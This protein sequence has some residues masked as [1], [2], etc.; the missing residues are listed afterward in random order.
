MHEGRRARD[1]FCVNWTRSGGGGRIDGGKRGGGKGEGIG[2]TK[3]AIPT[4]RPC[5]A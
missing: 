3:T 4:F 1:R 2:D 5:M